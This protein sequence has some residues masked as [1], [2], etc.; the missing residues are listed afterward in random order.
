M[1]LPLLLA[2]AAIPSVYKAGSGIVQAIR[3]KQMA[4]NNQRPTYEIPQAI[5]GN[6]KLAANAYA[7]PRLAGQD[8]MEDNL[9]SATATG[10][11]AAKNISTDSGDIL[12]AVSRLYGRESAG[13]NQLNLAGA[14]QQQRDLAQLMGANSQLGAY[15][16]LAF[17]YNK[18]QPYQDRAGASSALIEAGNQNIYGGLDTLGSLTQS[19]IAPGGALASYGRKRVPPAN[20]NSSWVN[21][22]LGTM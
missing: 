22:Q 15:Q 5:A 8:I 1:P 4:R 9:R 10:L 21:K 17:D 11:D 13:V 20:T 7:D 18:N 2:A 14:Q 6:Q 16:D 19:F 12:D 3:G